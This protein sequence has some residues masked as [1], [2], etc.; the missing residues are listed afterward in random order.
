M[1]LNEIKLKIMSA[2]NLKDNFETPTFEVPSALKKPLDLM[3]LSPDA[4]HDL[5]FLFYRDHPSLLIQ[6]SVP[7]EGFS[8]FSMFDFTVSKR[9]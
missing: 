9:G 8:V 4:L 7:K 3:T 6:N 1:D 2:D 5:S